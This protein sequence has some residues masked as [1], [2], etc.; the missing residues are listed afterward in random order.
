MESDKDSARP[1]KEAR[2]HLAEMEKLRTAL[3]ATHAQSKELR[4]HVQELLEREVA[5]DAEAASH[6][7]KRRLTR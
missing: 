6:P 2:A 5:A 4:T 3:E 7:T 1:D